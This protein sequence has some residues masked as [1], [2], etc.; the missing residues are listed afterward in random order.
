GISASELARSLHIPTNRITQI[1]KGQRGITA[2]TALR[3]GRWFGTGAELWLNLQKTYELRLAQELAGEE[4][5]KTI[6]PRSSI[7]NQPLVQV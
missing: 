1:L 7:N 2:D 5:K 6:Q 4:I 3:L